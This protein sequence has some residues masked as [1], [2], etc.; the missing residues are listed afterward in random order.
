ME[1]NTQDLLDAGSDI[2]KSVTKAIDTNDYSKLASE[3][4]STV[5]SVSI[6]RRTTY[7]SGRV[8]EQ[9]LRVVHRVAA[10]RARKYPF[11][12]K[13]VSKYNGIL[14][15]ILGSSLGFCF[16]WAFFGCLFTNIPALIITWLALTIGSGLIG[17]RGF[18]K[19]K[20][21]K[22]YHK[23]GNILKDAEFFNVSDL[24]Q[25]ALETDEDV[26]KN[27]KGMMD[28][29]YLPRGRFDSTQS[30]FM[31]T[32]AAYQL[33]LGAEQDRLARE[34][35]NVEQ[36]AKDTKKRAVE[37]GLDPKVQSILDEGSEYIAF[38]RHINDIVPDSEEMSNKLYKLES[39]MNKIFEQ[40]KKE[41]E[42]ADDLHKLMNY[43]LP[44]TKKLLTAYV[45]LDRQQAG[46]GENVKQTKREIETVMDTINEAF[47][48]LLDSLF[49]DLAWDISSDIS[50]MKTMMAQ[51]GLTE[52][53]L[54]SGVSGVATAQA[55]QTAGGAMAQAQQGVMLEFD[56]K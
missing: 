6:E 2:L 12:A 1:K 8:P 26:R 31:I 23:Y 44:T 15:G 53:A 40:V 5:K 39:I 11:L 3:I 28:L 13:G 9:D 24:A 51:D 56:Q 48:N 21:S 14:E 33:Y 10:P 22:E 38:V 16:F 50:V 34:Q 49:Q 41:P 55:A 35:V 17:F 27:L 47:A 52:D 18:K 20:L 32:D 43:Y 29:G 19:L 25:A 7:A 54:M 45:D 36:K 46:N 30:T 37:N 4:A 42:T